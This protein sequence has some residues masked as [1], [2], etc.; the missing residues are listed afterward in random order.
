MNYITNFSVSI[1]LVYISV[2]TVSMRIFGA[3]LRKLPFIVSILLTLCSCIALAVLLPSE[4]SPILPIY[5]AV[6]GL[7]SSLVSLKNIR[8]ITV[9]F[10]TACLHLIT[11]ILISASTADRQPDS[12][13]E[14]LSGVFAGVTVFLLCAF[15]SYSRLRQR[16][17]Y[18]LKL[19]PSII[20]IIALVFLACYAFLSFSIL[21]KPFYDDPAWSSTVKVIFVATLVIMALLLISL[22]I[23]STSNNHFK[24]LTRYYENQIEKQSEYYIRLS[25]SNFRL[26]KFKHDFNNMYIGLTGLLENGKSKEALEM[27]RNEKQELALYTPLFDTGNGIA[28]AL[29]TDKARCAEVSGTTIEFD[30][31]FPSEGIKPCDLCVLL[32]NPLDNAIEA[33][34]KTKSSDKK[35]IK[36]CCTCSSGFLFIEM[37]NPV[38]NKVEFFGGMP[39]SDKRS[40][41][42][43]GFGLYS[44]ELVVSQ[45]KGEL[46]LSC[47]NKEFRVS[48][49]LPIESCAQQS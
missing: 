22:A 15:I 16:V 28:D 30:G 48:V 26:R 36:V 31:A 12:V 40:S 43:H 3:N 19:T 2:L 1:L 4:Y 27:I 41:D 34:E 13:P 20:K 47:D 17:R 5:M 23:Y 44:L 14:I 35:I 32:G 6:A 45:Y 18:T 10:L 39:V 21:N 33:C 37:T 29:L 49:S 7:F 11:L 24:R 8:S 38:A 42:V 9:V 25:E 46:K